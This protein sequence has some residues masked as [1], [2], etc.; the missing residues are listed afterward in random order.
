MTMN[1]SSLLH[2]QWAGSN[3]NPRGNDGEGERGTDRSNMVT[4][5]NPNLNI[6]VNELEYEYLTSER[7][8]AKWWAVLRTDMMPFEQAF[9]YCRENDMQLP[10]PTNEDENEAFGRIPGG[11]FF[12]GIRSVFEDLFRNFCFS[13]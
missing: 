10:V 8:E 5:K 4:V 7:K 3:S 9:E 2:I 1:S 6:P 12:L 13:F 11:N